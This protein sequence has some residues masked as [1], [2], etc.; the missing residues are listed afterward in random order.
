MVLQSPV[1]IQPKACPKP[2]LKTQPVSST[3]RL[4]AIPSQKSEVSAGVSG[5]FAER[6]E[7]ESLDPSW[8]QQLRCMV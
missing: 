4:K 2:K 5:R 8:F 6:T 3:P 1:I 7:E